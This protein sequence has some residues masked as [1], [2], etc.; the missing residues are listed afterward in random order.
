MHGGAGG[1]I[2]TQAPLTVD[3]EMN[4]IIGTLNQPAAFDDG[5][6]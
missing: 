4:Q 1:E 2:P 5:I 6:K 3:Q